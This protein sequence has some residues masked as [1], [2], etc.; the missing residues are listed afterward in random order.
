M[1]SILIHKIDHIGD[2]LLAT[3][4]IRALRESFPDSEITAI[5]TPLTKDVLDGNADINDMVLFDPEWER[6]AKEKF[7]NFAL[8][9]KK[10]AFDCIISF[11]AATK[12]YRMMKKFGGK[13]RVAPVYKHMLSA[14]LAALTTLT[15]RIMINDDP[16]Q[17][18][19]KRFQLRHEVEQNIEVVK[20]VGAKALVA[21]RL[22]LPV[23]DEDIKWAKE[24]VALLSLPRKQSKI[25]GLQLSNRWFW[26]HMQIKGLGHLLATFVKFYPTG[27]FLVFCDKAEEGMSEELKKMNLGA[28]VEFLPCLPLKRYAAMLRQCNAFVTM[29]SGATHIASAVGTQ[30]VVVF[31]ER[32]FDYFSVREAPWKTPHVIVKKPFDM[33]PHQT[34]DEALNSAM[35]LHSR[36]IVDRLQTLL[37]DQ[38]ETLY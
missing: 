19:A 33:L 23:S 5:V 10:R 38:E 34:T 4:A 37:A 3:P 8:E 35:T 30:L 25:V 22:A 28:N 12:D 2:T 13:T 7:A 16:G 18:M 17:F 6:K 31:R 26:P 36:E 21:S 11:S 14:R 24:R 20:A 1:R 32:W 29:H 15:Q 27:F 9:M